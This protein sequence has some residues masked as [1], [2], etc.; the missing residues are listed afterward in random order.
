MIWLIGNKGMLGS[1]IEAELRNCKM[2]FTASDKEV[3]ITDLNILKKYAGDKNFTWI[4]NCSAYT[5]V[6]K[7]EDEEEIAFKV[8]AQGTKNISIVARE[9]NAKLIHFSTDYVFNGFKHSEY[10]EDDETNPESI[11]GKSKLQGELNIK[12]EWDKSFI[13]RI[14]WLFGKNGNNFVYTM[15]RLFEEKDEVKVVC[16]QWG[17]PTYS[18]E[19]SKFIIKIVKQNPVQYGVYHFSCEGKTSWY[20]FAKRVYEKSKEYQ[21]IKKNVIISSIKTNEYPTKAK[22]P[23]NSS[24]SKEKIKKTFNIEINKWQES[25]DS[26]LYDIAGNK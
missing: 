7:A 11:Y 24:F 5:A 8:N 17:S 15:L 23:K 16:D 1:D 2:P 6:D 22:R 10:C 26:F 3:D 14:S 19:L 9:K 4:I 20:E 18:K 21:L 12:E 13:F 25:V